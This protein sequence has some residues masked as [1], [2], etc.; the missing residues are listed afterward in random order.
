LEPSKFEAILEAVIISMAIVFILAHAL[1]YFLSGAHKNLG[2]VK[3]KRI[4]KPKKKQKK[5]EEKL[6]KPSISAR[7]E[8]K[9]SSNY[10]KDDLF[11]LFDDFS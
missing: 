6:K 3:F 10:S 1:E 7:Y 5:I 9:V 2:E 11:N 8:S 4:E